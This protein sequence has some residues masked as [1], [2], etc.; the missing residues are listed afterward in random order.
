MAH[1]HD[2][3]NGGENGGVDLSEE[4]YPPGAEYG[5]GHH[6]HTVVSPGTL[7]GVLVVLLLLTGL[8]VAFAELEA[9]IAGLFEIT[10]P[11]WVNAVVA[12]SIASVKTAFVVL[13][14]MQLR[15]DNPLNSM[16]FIFTLITVA[17]FLGFT[18]ID[19]GM[20]GTIDPVKARYI[21]PGGTGIET[22]AAKQ[23]GVPTNAPVTEIARQA[24]LARGEYT[25][26]EPEPVIGSTPNLSRPRTGLTLPGFTDDN[27]GR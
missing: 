15:Y 20:R 13:Y 21:Q 27:G 12:L 14:F 8:T 2:N 11:Q 6:G 9:W 1:N 25:P 24:A 5:H 23:T 22:R 7:I 17:F 16:I 3:P 10:I 18:M 26:K 19:L 4:I